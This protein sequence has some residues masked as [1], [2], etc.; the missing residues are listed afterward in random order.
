MARLGLIFATSL[1]I[2]LLVAGCTGTTPDSGL[3]ANM[4]ISN[5]QFYRGKPPADSGGPAL[6]NMAVRSLIQPGLTIAPVTGYATSKTTGIALYLDNDAGYWIITP[7]VADPTYDYDLTFSANA[8]F[9][10]TLHEGKYTF[11]GRAIDVDGHFGPRFEF[12]IQT[13]DLA[14]PP[15]STLLVSLRWDREADLDLHL[16]LPD[17]KTEIYS[18]KINSYRPPPPTQPPDDPNAY[19]SG[20]I[21]D[22][23]SNATCIIDGRRVENIYWT[24]KPPSGHYIARVDTY[25]LCGEAQAIF[26]VGVTL[27]DKSLGWANGLSRDTDTNFARGKGAGVTAFE[28]DVP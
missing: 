1:G 21:L 17:G 25:S 15:P 22:Y 12:P 28:F 24:Q 18:D 7:G 8:T 9:S 11:V 13:M 10:P 20:G 4:R 23:D 5:A 27:N 14:T 3:D 19:L 2:A 16:I 26:Q 6:A